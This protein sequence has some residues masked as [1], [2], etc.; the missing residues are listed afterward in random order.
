MSQSFETFGK[1]IL[2]EKLATGGMAEVYLA[3]SNQG[4]NNIS[5]FIAIKRILPQFAEN[6]EFLDMFRLEA[7]IAV[8]L[9]HSNIVS[10]YDFGVEKRQPFLVMDYVE[11]RNL[12]QVLNRMKKGEISFSIEQ[13]LYIIRE[14]AAGLDHAHRCLDGTTGKPL[15]I[16]HRDISPQNVMVSFEGEVK[17]VDFGIAKAESQL[18]V[19]RAGTLKGKFGYMSPEQAEGHPVD[20]RTDIFSLGIAMWELLANDRL[21]IAKDETQTLR[22]I[23]ECQVPPLRKINPSIPQELERICNKALA[24]DRNLRYQTAAD[25]HRDLSRFLNR[26]YPDFSPHDFSLF[27]KNL[28]SSEIL[29]ARRKQ[30]EYSRL[31]DKKGLE[32]EIVDFKTEITNTDTRKTETDADVPQQPVELT[33]SSPEEV[34]APF[35]SPKPGD[36][37]RTDNIPMPSSKKRIPPPM[38]QPAQRAKVSP[39]TSPKLQIEKPR[40]S[41]FTGSY[42]PRSNDIQFKQNRSYGAFYI[43]AIVAGVLGYFAYSNPAEFQKQA[44][45]IAGQVGIQLPQQYSSQEQQ[46]EQASS[47]PVARTIVV[48][49]QPSGAEITVDAVPFKD[50]TPA[51]I[52]VPLNQEVQITVRLPGYVPVTKTFAARSAEKELAVQLTRAKLGYVDISVIGSGAIYIDGVK[53]KDAGPVTNYPI[54]ADQNVIVRVYDTVTK[55]EDSTVVRVP[56]NRVKR[57][58]LM[59]RMRSRNNEPERNPSRQ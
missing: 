9:S 15:N 58:T 18:E 35:F 37:G 46:T 5:K 39:N 7:R 29:D 31:T 1:Y 51:S 8:N 42:S 55:S 54:A 33:P 43:L 50:L 57:I 40:E 27:I 24:K 30:I 23:R 22:K 53:V 10:I 38:P 41:T 36:A 3:K 11:G 56:E 49:S 44:Y 32:P 28:F 59:P 17:V 26:Q 19:T 25:F 4:H 2:L 16:T 47:A 34:D 48:K 14:V 45:R 6:P 12:R 20:L 13:A 21:F 52:E